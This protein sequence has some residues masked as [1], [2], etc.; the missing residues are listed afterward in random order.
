M[1][2]TDIKTYDQFTSN[3]TYDLQE[4]Y[5]FQ[6]QLSI[7]KNQKLYGF[8][9]SHTPLSSTTSQIDRIDDISVKTI[10]FGGYNY[11]GYG[12]DV[13]VKEAAKEAIDLYGLGAYSSP[14]LNGTL[15]IHKQ[16]EKKLLDFFKLD[17]HGITLFPTGFCVGQGTIQAFMS[18]GSFIIMDEKAHASMIEGA[19]LS[20]ATILYFKHNDMAD[21]EELLS[22]LSDLKTRKLICVEGVYSSD[23]DCCPLDKLVK[24]AKKYHA[25]TLVDEA[26]SVLIAGDHG[27]GV[28]EQFGVL[29]QIDLYIMTFSKSFGGGGGALLAKKEVSDYINL[30]A[31]CRAF[32]CALNPGLAGGL[33]QVLELASGEDGDR[34]R[35]AIKGN[36]AYLYEKLAPYVTIPDHKN[37]VLPV[38][39][40]SE[41]KAFPIYNFLHQNGL[42][43]SIHIYPAVPK[44]TARIRLF[45][46]SEH[47]QE[48]LGT[49]ADIIIKTAR[50]FGFSKQD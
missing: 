19:Q 11:L 18:S 30:Y 14:V 12:T 46:S 24:L 1:T 8:E 15:H 13:R 33:I 35:T 43:A 39:F 48:Q 50:T 22:D 36:A 26:H 7:L 21:L 10:N 40:G 41:E 23:G 5:A 16:L 9:A 20:G 37:W 49:C 47:T 34:R 4:I 28:C 38:I 2:P 32:S 6:D 31:S 27:R 3:S 45:I 17:D 25:Y 42:D 44:G 29:D